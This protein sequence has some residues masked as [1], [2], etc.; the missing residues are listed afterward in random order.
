MLAE[1]DRQTPLGRRDFA[2][3]LT[4]ATYGMGAAEAF[5]L[6]LDDID[7]LR[8]TLNVVRPKTGTHTLLPLL[9]PVG[10]AIF[11]YLRKGRPRSS[12]GDKIF[13]S[14]RPPYRWVENPAVVVRHMLKKYSSAAG[15]SLPSVGSHLLRHTYVSRQVDAGVSPRVIS[16]IVGHTHGT[17]ISPYLRIATERLRS[18]SLPLP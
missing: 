16:D 12:E 14:G 5:S 2:V 11:A 1:V 17:A 3:L 8:G 9:Q 7:W 4:M 6:T 13:V 18:V 15:V 10:K